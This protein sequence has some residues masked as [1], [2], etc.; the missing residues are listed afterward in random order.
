MLNA[1]SAHVAI[2]VILHFGLSG[3]L[4]QALCKKP[5]WQGMPDSWSRLDG[6]YDLPGF[7]LVFLCSGM[8]VYGLGALSHQAGWVRWNTGQLNQRA[9][10]LGARLA[11]PSQEP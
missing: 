3:I 8:L 1:R 10:Q 9:R 6:Q 11:D 7:F 5:D 2:L 4:F